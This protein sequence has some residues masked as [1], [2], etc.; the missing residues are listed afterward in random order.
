MTISC[1]S[2]ISGSLPIARNRISVKEQQKQQHQQQEQVSPSCNHPLIMMHHDHNDHHDNNLPA[3][4]G[5]SLLLLASGWLL[6]FYTYI[7]YLS[8]YRC[9][10]KKDTK[11]KPKHYR[12]YYGAVVS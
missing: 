6:C 12:T 5:I 10:Y 4:V 9:M 3:L 2:Q 11:L 7:I 1:E 8:I